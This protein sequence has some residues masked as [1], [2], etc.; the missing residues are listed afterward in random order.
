MRATI[1]GKVAWTD[2]QKVKVTLE[3][4]MVK[5]R[6]TWSMEIVFP[7]GIAEN[8]AAFG[9]VDRIDVLKR[10]VVYA[11]CELFAGSRRVIHGRGTV[12]SYS[13]DSLKLQIVSGREKYRY[14][15]GFQSTYIDCLDY[16]RTLV[17]DRWDGSLRSGSFEEVADVEDREV[18]LLTPS[19]FEQLQRLYAEEAVWASVY[20]DTNGV[21]RNN[22]LYFGLRG[23]AGKVRVG[24]RCPQP[25]LWYVVEVCFRHF[26]YVF[27]RGSLPLA[28]E[29]KDVCLVNVFPD[30]ESFRRGLPHWSVQRF[31]DEVEHLFNMTFVLDDERH[32]V[33]MSPNVLGGREE[34]VVAVE[35]EFIGDYE[36]TGFEYI[37]ASGISYD[38]SDYHA[39]TDV[40][41]QVLED[42]SVREYGSKRRAEQAWRNLLET[43]EK[44]L[45]T[46]IFRYPEG[47]FCTHR[48]WSDREVVYSRKEIGQLQHLQ[49]S[50]DA[51]DSAA[52]VVSLHL[53]P[54]PVQLVELPEYFLSLYFPDLYLNDDRDGDKGRYMPITENLAKSS[55]EDL[56]YRTVEDALEGEAAAPEDDTDR[57]EI[58]LA[59]QVSRHLPDGSDVL[60]YRASTFTGSNPTAQHVSTLSLYDVPRS[61]GALHGAR[62]RIENKVRMTFRFLY[63]GMPD[64]TLVYVIR[65]KRFLCDKIEVEITDEDIYPLK[66]GYFYEI[67]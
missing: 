57:I 4:Y 9:S 14:R 58:F 13:Q 2:G 5:N 36:E 50:S 35:D 30:P 15:E 28:E 38:L 10:K 33:T 11:D 1:N 67:L 63:D 29:W 51:G 53:S 22:F 6:Q 40:D 55:S 17:V 7:M 12:T 46:T 52:D 32:V 19:H 37:G 23:E 56:D 18:L 44:T 59:S 20:D 45:M 43:D 64:P 16:G 49:R 65:G 60:F 31:L 25:R 27:D 41:D 62:R 39:G 47:M 61:I 48:E 3:N 34:V 21:V 8:V 42:F 26:G 66:T 54:A 24:N